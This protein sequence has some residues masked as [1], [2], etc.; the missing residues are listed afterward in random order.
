MTFDKIY[1]KTIEELLE[2]ATVLT[3][4]QNKKS[5]DLTSDIEKEMGDVIFWTGLLTTRLDIEKV[6]ERI[7]KKQKKYKKFLDLIKTKTRNIKGQ[8]H[9]SL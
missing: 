8:Q 9:L 6:Q 1:K 5:K 3:Q 4:Q 2:L 7:L